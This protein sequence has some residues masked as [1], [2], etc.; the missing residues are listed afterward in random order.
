MTIEV[1]A[2][3]KRWDEFVDKS[4]YGMLFHKWDFL[5]IAEK[6]TGYTLYPYGIYKGSELIAVFPVFVKRHMGMG[7]VY[8][9][10]PRSG[11]PYLGLVPGP[12]LDGLKQPRRE[13]YL[14]LI[15]ED[16][17]GEFDKHSTKHV[18]FSLAPG[19]TDIRQFLWTGYEESVK[20]TYTLDLRRPL[21]DLWKDLDAKTRAQIN[22][23]QA[24]MEQKND[25]GVFYR[26][27]S[28]R[29]SQQK[30]EFSNNI[31]SGE[32]L[33]DLLNAY[34]DNLKMYF[35]RLNGEIANAYVMYM[36][37]GRYLEWLGAVNLQKDAHTNEFMRWHFIKEAKA[38]AYDTFE[39]YGADVIRICRSKSKFNPTLGCTYVVQKKA[40]SGKMAESVYRA[41]SRT[42]HILKA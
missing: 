22:K 6:H 35:A 13:T 31:V 8:S 18:Y 19:I 24:S 11:I 16:L 5:K 36:Y 7:M 12:Q 10:P 4:R 17:E 41:I 2:D 23:E 34:P 15:M 29:Y 26:I 30:L 33:A 40:L 32:Y 37:K 27:L 21:E 38:Q 28:D 9:P 20:F 3:S 25:A 14:Q 1:L 42:K 39:I